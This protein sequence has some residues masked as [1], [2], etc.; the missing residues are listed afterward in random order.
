M[1][2]RIIIEENVEIEEEKVIILCKKL[3]KKLMKAI[4]LLKSKDT[5]I[6]YKSSAMHKIDV[7]SIYYFESVEKK[8]FVYTDNEVYES[9]DKLTAIEQEMNEDFI[10]ISRTMIVNWQKIESLKP[11]LNGRLEARLDNEERLIISRQYVTELKKRFVY[12]Q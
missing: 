3:S 12:G 2:I 11:I 1:A 9:K 5:L 6:V 4:D 10:R 8:L 7:E